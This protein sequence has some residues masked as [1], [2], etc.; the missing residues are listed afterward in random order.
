MPETT[1]YEV[2][3]TVEFDAWAHGK[4]LLPE[5]RGVIETYLDKGRK[6]LEAGTGGGRILLA[7]RA[8]GFTDLHGF[9]YVPEFI[10]EARA[11]DPQQTITFEVQDATALRYADASFD[12]LLYLQ[13]VLCFIEDETGRAKAAREA[14]RILKPGGTAIFSFL[15]FDVR[16]RR[17]A[18]RC[19]LAYLRALRL[20]P[21]KRRAIQSSPWLK[22]GNKLNFGA[23]TDRGPYVY[24]YRTE[25]AWRLLKDA[26][27]EITAMGTVPQIQQKKMHASWETLVREPLDGM[28]YCVCR[29]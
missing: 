8:L 10:E 27:F 13:Q 19:Y 4:D 3:S 1:N 29:K 12:Q 24:W 21:W 14:C 18:Y 5:E 6:T 16:R 22:L 20:L 7:M 9:D 11:R 23:L 15:A 17:L 28:L 25:E 26:G 2:Y